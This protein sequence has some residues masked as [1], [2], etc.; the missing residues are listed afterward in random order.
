M[1]F[2]LNKI[3]G[4]IREKLGSEQEFTKQMGLTPK[5]ISLKLNGKIEFKR[6]EI[7]RACKILEIA[8]SEVSEYFFNL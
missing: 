3:R 1:A 7:E 6:S 5:P 4:R 8:S 2:D